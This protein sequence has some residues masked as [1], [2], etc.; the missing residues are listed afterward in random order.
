MPFIKVKAY[1]KDAK[2]KEKVADEINEVFLRNWGCPPEA[3]TIEIEE[4][5]PENWDQ[6]KEAEITPRADKMMILDGKKQYG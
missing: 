3:I 4:I 1:P 6:V 2:I 5:L